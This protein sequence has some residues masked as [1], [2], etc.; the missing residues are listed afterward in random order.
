VHRP[1]RIA[2]VGA[3]LGGLTC[4]AFLQ[5]AGFAVTVYEQ[6]PAFSRIGAGI[7]LSA[8][9]MKVLRRLG[10]ERR[11]LAAGITPD[12]FVSRA[13]DSG[14]ILYEL[15]L[16]AASEARFGGPYINIHRGDLHAVLA[17]AVAPDT[18]RFGQRLVGLEPRAEAVRLVFET[19]LQREA[20]IVI[21]ADGIRSQVR[22]ILFGAEAP[23]FTGRI[24][25]RAIF[26]AARLRG[27]A[28]RDCSKWWGPDRHILA[29]FVTHRRDEVYVMG[30]VPGAGWD[31]DQLLLTRPGGELLR[32][33]AHFHAS[34]RDLLAAAT[35]ITVTPICDRQRSDRWT[36][37]RIALL[38]D[39]CHPMR[40]YM[41]AGG[42]MAVE[43]AAVLA[44]C[45]VA[46]GDGD[47]DEALRCYAATR[48]P[49]VG[50]VQRIS[51]DNSW[52]RGPTD[53]E[54]FFAYDACLAPLTRPGPT[55]AV[56]SPPLADCTEA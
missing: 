2:V 21:G 53:T 15:P 13:W 55:G 52:L 37:S 47:C 18:I 28:L 32:S 34:I 16:D 30:S 50:E 19:G 35:E 26:P 56:Y 17:T 24:A 10:L 46:F 48:I 25:Q 20:D 51:I 39:A 3:G 45:L 31:D 7:I 49:R 29:Y 1:N 27:R 23:R 6:S 36:G 41:A 14:E 42:A 4:A 33:F 38:G 5:R 8:N 11:L 54:W 12:A 22:D 9:V 44:R 43:D 40:P